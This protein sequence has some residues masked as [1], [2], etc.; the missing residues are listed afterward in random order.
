M[1]ISEL[2]SE[3]YVHS[4][5]ATLV[6]YSEWYLGVFVF[7]ICRYFSVGDEYYTGEQEKYF[8]WIWVK[9]FSLR[10]ID[11]CSKRALF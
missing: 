1:F 7:V 8:V 2:L 10:N 9:R 11:F 3:I 4:V 6:M 5:I